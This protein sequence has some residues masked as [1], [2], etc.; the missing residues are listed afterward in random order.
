LAEKNGR[1]R[2]F[3]KKPIKDRKLL[4]WLLLYFGYR[5]GNFFIWNGESL[6]G[7]DVY[8][9]DWLNLVG[10]EPTGFTDMISSKRRLERRKWGRKRGEET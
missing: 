8:L 1:I 9:S 7:L 2:V 4:L 3:F 6:I 5:R 10:S